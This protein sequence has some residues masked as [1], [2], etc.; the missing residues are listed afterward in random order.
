MKRVGFLYEKICDWENLMLAYHKAKSGKHSA[1]IEDFKYDWELQL[2]RIQQELEEGSF[3][4][5]DYHQ[6]MIYE[7]KERQITA[8]PF[9]DRVVHHAICNVVGPILDKP[10]VHTSYA[11]RKGKGLHRAVKQA[12]FMYRHSSHHYRLDIG[13]FYYT[14]DHEILM[15]LIKRKIKDRRVL[16]L[17][18][19]LLATHHSG[20]EYYFPFEGDDLFDMIRARGLPIGNLTSQLFANFY[21]SSLDHYVQEKLGFSSYIRYMDDIIVFGNDKESLKNARIQIIEKLDG[22]R[23]KVNERKDSVQSNSRGVDFLGFRFIGNR[24]RVRNQ[25]L[26]RFRRK[27]KR[28][29]K[30]DNVDLTKLLQSFNGHLGYLMAAKSHRIIDLILND[31]EYYDQHKRW[32]LTCLKRV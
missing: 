4:F 32:K 24:I 27:M 7:P 15:G 11:C 13:K 6:F 30:M 9:R 31:I 8:A 14:I 20:K 21:L 23:L 10:L 12:F 22:L 25:N 19:D 5:G 26:V 16:A 2:Y 1:A 3:R 17:I 18:G 28:A 29:S